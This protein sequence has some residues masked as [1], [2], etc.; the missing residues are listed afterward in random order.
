[1]TEIVPIVPKK[2]GNTRQISPAVGWFFTFNNYNSQDI[3]DM[4]KYFNISSKEYLFQEEIGKE[5]TPHLQGFVNLVEKCRY[6]SIPL[7][8]KIHWEK[9]KGSTKQNIVYCTKIDTSVGRVYTNMDLSKYQLFEKLLPGI[10]GEPLPW[11]KKILEIISGPR[12][13]RKIYWIVDK[14]GG[15]GKSALCRHISI[16][17]PGKTILLSGKGA[18]LKYGV[19]THLAKNP[20]NPGALQIAMFDFPRTL[21]G[22]VS[23]SGIEEIKN[24]HFFSGKYEGCEVLFNPPHLLC[25]SNFDPDLSKLSKD[26]WEIIQLGD[27]LIPASPPRGEGQLAVEAPPPPLRETGRAVGGCEWDNIEDSDVTI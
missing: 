1:M 21:E 14:F 10:E 3:E 12:H 19:V 25:F 24:G 9:R 20:G 23:Y 2:F 11:Q 22:F 27:P 6:D 13:R 15:Q 18:D 4:V 5:G 8:K 26:R 16:L 17:N 7:S